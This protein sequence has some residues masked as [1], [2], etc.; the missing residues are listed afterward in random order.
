MNTS[1]LLQILRDHPEHQLRFMLPDG[2]MIPAHA[3]VTE[4]GRVDKTFLDCGGTAR[5][6][7]SLCLQTW[8]ADDVD[9]RLAAGKLADIIDRAAPILGNDDLVAEIEYED[10]FISQFPIESS[11]TQ[12]DFIVF[13]LGTKHTDCL[14]KDICLPKPQE[15]SSSCCT[16]TGCC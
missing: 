4:V 8:V 16:G 12:G 11:A 3:H 5:R 14:A 13:R 7:S 2:G 9:H 6:V 15:N 1:S 10:G